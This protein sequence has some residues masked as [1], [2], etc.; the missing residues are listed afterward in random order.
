MSEEPEGEKCEVCASPLFVAQ[1]CDAI[2]GDKECKE[3]TERAGRGEITQEQY[4]A[5]VIEKY[6]REKVAMAMEKALVKDRMDASITPP[7]TAGA[8]S[9][10]P[11]VQAPGPE[12]PKQDKEPVAKTGL[13]KEEEKLATGIADD[14]EKKE[15]EERAKAGMPKFK[16]SLK[17]MCLP[18]IGNTASAIMLTVKLWYTGKDKEK[19]ENAEKQM[20]NGEINVEDAIKEVFLLKEGKTCYNTVLGEINRITDLGTELAIKANPGLLEEKKGK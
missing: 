16:T 20:R 9:V 14:K 18:C 13:S 11:E 3:L 6:G 8:K 4:Y 7:T 2:G 1:F 10:Q 15:M 5:K 19:I 17:G 12:V